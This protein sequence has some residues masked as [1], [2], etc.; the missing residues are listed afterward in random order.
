MAAPEASFI[1]VEI[2]PRRG[3]RHSLAAETTF[4]RER[5]DILLAD[6]EVS[7]RHAAIRASRDRAEIEDL[8]SR[9]GTFV[10]AE[11]VEGVRALADGDTVRLGGT[12]WRFQASTLGET[13]FGE[14]PGGSADLLPRGRSGDVPAPE[15]APSAVHRA[16]APQA[17]AP[18]SFASPARPRHR[19]R[20]SAA[21]RGGAVLASYAAVIAT[22]AAVIAYFV[23]R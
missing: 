15:A 2:E 10:N 19:V 21:R 6:E 1:L 5:C 23:A 13:T 4:G 16:P 8:G 20:G 9:N 14:L 11:R 12:S 17:S 3:A 7:R 22:A 18:P